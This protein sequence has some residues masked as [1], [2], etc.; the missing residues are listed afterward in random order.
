MKNQSFIY[1]G[2]CV[3]ALFLILGNISLFGYV[4]TKFDSFAIFG[5]LLLIYGTLI[6]LLIVIILFVYGLFEKEQ[7][8]YC[9]S[10]IGY[11]S[12]NIPI[13]ILYAVIGLNLN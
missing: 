8:K 6:N 1:F 13:A 11:I 9:L 10:A 4:L 2:K 5:F 7:F 3:F 12:I